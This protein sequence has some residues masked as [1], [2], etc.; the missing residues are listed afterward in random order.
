MQEGKIQIDAEACNHCGRC[1]NKCPFGAVNESAAGYRIYIG[2]RWG[3]KVAQGHMLDKLFTSEEEVID[4]VER[5]I[6]FSATREIPGSALRTPSTGW[7]L[8]MCRK[9]CYIMRLTARRF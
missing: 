4:L 8:T 1:V 6:L 5:A 9:N 2:G 7:D 3:K